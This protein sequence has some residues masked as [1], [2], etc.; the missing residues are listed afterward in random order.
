MCVQIDKGVGQ[1]SVTVNDGGVIETTSKTIPILLQSVTVDVYP[2]GGQCV[3]HLPCRVY[4]EATGPSGDPVDV[5]GN[6]CAVGSAAV[7]ATV[8][9]VHEGR[10]VSTLFTPDSAG[11]MDSTSASAWCILTVR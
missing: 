2:E 6:I 5:S 10:G 9:T 3:L 8:S 11:T 7:V 4:I 1:L